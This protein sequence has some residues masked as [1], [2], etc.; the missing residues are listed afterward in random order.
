MA[1]AKMAGEEKIAARV[2]SRIRKIREMRH[3]SQ[4][5]LSQEIGIR[6]GPLGWIE[7]GQHIP[8][9]R[10]LY[11]IARALDVRLDDLFEEAAAWLPSRAT[12]SDKPLEAFVIFPPLVTQTEPAA[13]TVESTCL[14][15]KSIAFLLGKVL[16]TQDSLPHLPFRF[17]IPFV[18]SDASAEQSANLVRNQLGIG[19]GV[20][21]DYLQVLE[22]AGMDTIFM[23]LPEGIPALSGYNPVLKHAAI[24]VNN[25]YNRNPEEQLFALLMEVG[26][27]F[28][29][30][31]AI[32]SENR[33]V[34]KVS[35]RLDEMTFGN[36]FAT[37]FLLPT[38]SLLRTIGTLGVSPNKWT[39]ELFLF[40][41]YRYGVTARQLLDRLS[42]LPFAREEVDSSFEV[43]A[44]LSAF[45]REYPGEEPGGHRDPLFANGRV[46][47]MVF[48]AKIHKC[49][50][51]RELAQLLKLLQQTRVKLAF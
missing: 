49:L 5:K 8:S 26:R 23:E 14:L 43:E 3:I 7:R 34:G 18:M 9:G 2:G 46:S 31:N 45:E 41:K 32:V 42:E 44:K 15:C 22:S 4:L 24:F 20:T 33:N 10:V 1:K 38:S 17:D 6:S 25:R 37:Y 19:S 16:L 12:P 28:W 40:V 11:R 39:W 21:T 47:A 13:E 27:L 30:V 51:D 50:K 36:R 48:M 29:Q 35:I